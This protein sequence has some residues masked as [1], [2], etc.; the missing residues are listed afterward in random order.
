ME[1]LFWCDYGHIFWNG[2]LDKKDYNLKVDAKYKH[3]YHFPWNGGGAFF[4][5]NDKIFMFSHWKKRNILN[6]VW[7]HFCNMVY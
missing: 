7:D 5:S 2:V 4:S 1:V 3:K 6:V